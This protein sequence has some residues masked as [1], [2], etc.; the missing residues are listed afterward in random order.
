M[1]RALSSQKVFH[2]LTGVFRGD[3]SATTTTTAGTATKGTETSLAFTS[4]ASF[5][6][7]DKFRVGA[8]GNTAEVNEIDSISTNDVTPKLPWSRN[9]ASG[10][11]ITKLDAEDLGAT[12]ENGVNLETSMGETPVVAGTQKQT[13]LYINQN[14]E[15]QMTFALRDFDAENL[16][17][18]LGLDETDTGIVGTNGVVIL[19]NEFATVSYCP[20]WFEGLLEDATAVTGFIYSA[21]VSSANQT[22]QFVEGQ[23]TIIPFTMR[24]NGNRSFL[25]E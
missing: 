22:L 23:P 15:E 4:A 17:A 19:P 24:S 1:T 10:E 7:G 2:Q 3:D 18:S 9:I 21:K 16:A 11:D 12:D 13:Y 25:L 5:A 20:W 8:N 14:V 6:V